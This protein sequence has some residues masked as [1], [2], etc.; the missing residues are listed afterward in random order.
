M[1][2]PN[3]H[4]NPCQKPHSV[5]KIR[6]SV[7]PC[8]F[9]IQHQSGTW[10]DSDE[11]GW[12]SKNVQTDWHPLP[13][14]VDHNVISTLI[15][16]T[17]GLQCM[18]KQ[19]EQPGQ[20]CPLMTKRVHGRCEEDIF[21]F[22]K[23][24]QC[25]ERTMEVYAVS[26]QLFWTFSA[27][28]MHFQENHGRMICFFVGYFMKKVNFHLAC[29]AYGWFG[30]ISV[31]SHSLWPKSEVKAPPFEARPSWTSI[32]THSRSQNSGRRNC[33]GLSIY[34]RKIL[35]FEWS[36]PSGMS[37]WH[38]ILHTVWQIFWQFSFWHAIWLILWH[39]F[40]LSIWHTFWHIWWLTLYLTRIMVVTIYSTYFL[41]FYLTY[42]WT[43]C[44]I[45]YLICHDMIDTFGQTRWHRFWHSTHINSCNIYIYIYTIF[46]MSLRKPTFYKK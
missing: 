29:T 33:L 36:P 15:A 2:Y 41:T 32:R 24:M 26:K 5:S 22:V 6:N 34:P 13:P 31:M 12:S 1:L 11:Y 44:L 38:Y 7:V 40:W 4:K 35:Y 28:L 21:C 43:C 3:M 19:L 16:G 8:A 42:I 45:Y 9:A 20:V 37:S 17:T 23:E 30:S 27:M 10:R 18:L 46:Y 39:V 25:E 14:L